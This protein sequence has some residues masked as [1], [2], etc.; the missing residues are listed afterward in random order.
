M[1]EQKQDDQQE[2]TYSSYLRIRDIA[3]KTCQ[4]RWTIERSGER[5]SEISV[6]AAQHD[7]DDDDDIAILFLQE[8]Q[9]AG[10]VEYTGCV[11]AEG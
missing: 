4:R 2:P 8:T 9:S 6:L 1:A 10:A 5:G 11:Y 3:L 7:D